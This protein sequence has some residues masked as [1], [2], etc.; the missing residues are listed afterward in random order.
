[1]ALDFVGNSSQVN[2]SHILLKDGFADSIPEVRDKF[3]SSLDPWVDYVF[4][5]IMLII[6]KSF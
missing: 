4:G 2:S 6:G 1:M 5:V 3:K